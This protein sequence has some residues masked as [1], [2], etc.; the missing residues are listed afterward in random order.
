MTRHDTAGTPIA[1]RQRDGSTVAT[2]ILQSQ[3]SSKIR[4]RHLD[5]LAIVYVR[6]SSPQ[7]V[8]DHKESRER[9]YELVDHAL[10]LGWPKSRTLVIDEDQGRTAKKSDSRQGFQRLLAEVSMDHVGLILGLDMS[11]LSRTSRDWHH[12]LEVCALFGT[13]LADQDGVY[14][15][16]DS[17]DRLLL[18]LKGTMSE[19]EQFTMRNRL[20]RGKLH[21][22]ERGELFH[23]VPCGYVKL[24]SDSVAFDP[25]EQAHKAVQLIFDKFDEIGSIYGLFHYL[26]RNNIRM[27][28]RIQNGPQR[29][30]LIWRRPALPTL[31][32]ML[33]NPIY[34]GAYAYGRRPEG[35]R[36]KAS[37]QGGYGHRWVPMSEWKVLLRNRLPA[38][39]T[40]ERYLANLQRLEQN[41]SLPTS[42]GTPRKGAALLTGLLVCGSCGLRMHAAYRNKS[43]A[44]YSCERHLK[45]GTE[46]VCYG[47]RTTPVD[48]LVARQILLAL[49]PAALELSLQAAHD[50]RR[51][52]DRLHHHWKQQLERARY[53]SERAE[54]QYQAVEPENRMVV[55][56]L[57][58]RWEEALSKQRQLEDEYDR[59]Q[60]MQPSQL[61]E[62]ELARIAALSRDI[63]AL[64]DAPKTTAA[65][66]KEIIRLLIERVIVHVRKDSEYVD[67][68]IHWRGGFTST[69][70]VV[71]PVHR[72]EHM[73]DHDQL[74]G[75]ITAL[76]REGH[77]ASQI[78]SRLNSEG[79]RT[80][81]AR[82]SYT[83]SSVQQTITR[84][85]LT[86]ARKAERQLGRHEHS[87]PDLA[88]ALQMTEGKLRSW[89]VRGW[90]HARHS[91][92]QRLWIL[93]ADGQERRR[94]KR[95]VTCSARGVAPPA[96]L[97]TPKPRVKEC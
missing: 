16:N 47:L 70:E 34:A 22:A 18:G 33:H 51:E 56:T 42:P 26:I 44:Y 43:T 64:W 76:L 13:L 9:Q 62:D 39:I 55:R 20:E 41:R 61:G 91:P 68:T 30:Q 10:A 38:Y 25:D 69:H 60:R 7:Q 53:E 89:A 59:F 4:D 15:A 58:R 67:T 79:F 74:M 80:P 28:M 87:L 29:G 75:R 92:A 93:W 45:V 77:S 72:Y 2:P 97:T 83:S 1:P 3:R 94:L 52:R 24:P 71:R 82:G 31:N 32:Q 84:Y 96:E 40:W 11:R 12:L 17:N 90:V 49:E 46:Q 6:Q 37:R 50:V 27:G 5:R 63:P 95:L 85:G 8:L 88:R 57:E 48:D 86:E 66:R 73:R 35:P 14:D 54:R 23:K 36:T 19:F 65:D 78:A 21:K 81:K